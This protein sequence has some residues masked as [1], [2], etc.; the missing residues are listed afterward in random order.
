M[1]FISKYMDDL[2]Q[3]RPRDDLTDGSGVVPLIRGGT[4]DVIAAQ[5]R[6]GDHPGAR[7]DRRNEIAP[8]PAVGCY[9]RGRGGAC[10]LASATVSE[11]AW[12]QRPSLYKQL[13]FDPKSKGPSGR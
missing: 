11:P 8:E 10:R 2:E 6:K 9:E 1:V 13:S 5:R 12:Q 3:A 4:T 7:L